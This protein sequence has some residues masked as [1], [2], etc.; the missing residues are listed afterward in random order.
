M[1]ASLVAQGKRIHLQYRKCNTGDTGRADC[2]VLSLVCTKLY[3]I[4]TLH[5]KCFSTGLS[6]TEDSK[7]LDQKLPIVD[8]NMLVQLIEERGIIF[9]LLILTYIL[10]SMAELLLFLF[11]MFFGQF[12][13]A[14][15][16]GSIVNLFSSMSDFPQ[17]VTRHVALFYNPTIS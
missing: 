8:I 2:F 12:V 17:A 14:R 4:F 9:S 3:D 10:Q 16:R 6:P 11:Q 13:C 1:E 7:S 5:F 15:L